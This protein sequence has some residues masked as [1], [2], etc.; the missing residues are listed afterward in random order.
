MKNIKIVVKGTTPLLMNRM[1]E[2]TLQKLLLGPTAK[3]S[4]TRQRPA[5]TRD[6]ATGKVYTTS[7]GKPYLPAE[8]LL[9][10]LIEAGKFVR[11]DAKRQ[12][13]TAKATLLPAFLTLNDKFLLLLNPEKPGE[14]PTWEVDLRQGKNPNGGE[15]VCIC[16]PRFDVWGFE[17]DVQIDTDEIPEATIRTLWDHAGKR[18]GLGDF[19]PQRRGMFGQFRVDRWEAVDGTGNTRAAAELQL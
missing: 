8:N 7:D 17:A 15:A 11:L 19:R 18:V 6:E 14:A 16:R 3:G 2:D 4:K 13:S 10:C 9:A 12:V 1:S 5:S